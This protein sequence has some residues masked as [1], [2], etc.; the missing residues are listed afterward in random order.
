[1]GRLA[2]TLENACLTIAAAGLF[3][4]I[5]TVARASEGQRHPVSKEHPR[6]LGSR[7]DLQALAR[8]RADAYH[9]M[10]QLARSENAADPSIVISWALVAAIERDA[11]LGQKA[12]NAA[13]KLADGPIR[14]GHVP[15]AHDLAVGAIV[16]DLCHKYWTEP[17]RRRFHE[18]VNRTV[19]AN[20]QSET[21]VFHNGWYGYK[22]WGIGLARLCHA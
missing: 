10:A 6:L 17:E 3:F 5:G 22:N 7:A 1:M 16:Y 21:S 2:G 19:D 20:V 4:L 12:K 9:A 18:Y 11:G 13:L 8:E 14:A 15:F